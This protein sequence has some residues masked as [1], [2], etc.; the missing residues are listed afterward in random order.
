MS[1]HTDL[2]DFMTNNLPNS[3]C[4]LDYSVRDGVVYW[5]YEDKPVPDGLAE[6]FVENLGM[7]ALQSE[8]IGSV[9]AEQTRTQ[10]NRVD[11]SIYRNILG[12]LGTGTWT[13]PSFFARPGIMRKFDN[14]AAAILFLLEKRCRYLWPDA[15]T[16]VGERP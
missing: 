9:L 2:Y 3:L 10:E 15:D 11:Q 5:L 12:F 14:R 1:D 7:I 4:G 8:S 16:V 13:T 6:G